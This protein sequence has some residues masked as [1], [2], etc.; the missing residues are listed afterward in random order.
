MDCDESECEDLLLNGE[1]DFSLTF[2]RSS[3][4]D[5]V[6]FLEVYKDQL[7]VMA[8]SSVNQSDYQ[9]LVE[10]TKQQLNSGRSIAHQTD[11][12]QTDRVFDATNSKP[13][14]K[15]AQE[16]WAQ[17]LI[18]AGMGVGLVSSSAAA[19]VNPVDVCWEMVQE[20]QIYVSLIAGRFDSDAYT[21]FVGLLRNF[22]WVNQSEQLREG[23]SETKISTKALA[24]V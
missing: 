2:T 15:V 11:A 5:Q 14:V 20:R 6:Q 21:K 23:Y 9:S 4:D 3:K 17:Q 16:L 13:V 22:N 8:A 24:N 12:H 18:Q 10:F 7:G 19:L 1:V